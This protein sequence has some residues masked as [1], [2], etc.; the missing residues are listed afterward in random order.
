MTL[1]RHERADPGRRPGLRPVGPV[2]SSGQRTRAGL[3][4]RHSDV[5]PW[6]TR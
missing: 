3:V 1:E 2:V 6:G 4:P 5:C